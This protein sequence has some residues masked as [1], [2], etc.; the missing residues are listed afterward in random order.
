MAKKNYVKDFEAREQ[1]KIAG[2][3]V[4]DLWNVLFWLQEEHPNEEWLKRD[5]N[6]ISKL[7]KKMQDEFSGISL[8]EFNFAFFESARWD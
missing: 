3:S 5:I 2:S 8:T 7:L 6:T 1:G 4:K